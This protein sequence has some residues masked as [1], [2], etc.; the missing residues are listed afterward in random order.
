MIILHIS[1]TV[2]TL[3]LNEEFWLSNTN[4]NKESN[5]PVILK[6]PRKAE[7]SL[8]IMLTLSLRHHTGNEKQFG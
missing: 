2:N 3:S 6:N 5:L 8:L 1:S 7:T 4:L